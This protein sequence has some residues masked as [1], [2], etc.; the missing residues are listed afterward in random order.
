EPIGPGTAIQ[1][2]ALRRQ[3]H[4]HAGRLDPDED[5]TAREEDLVEAGRRDQALATL[6]EALEDLAGCRG[7][8]LGPATDSGSPRVRFG[9]QD[10]GQEIHDL[11]EAHS[12]RRSPDAELLLLE[13]GKLDRLV[14]PVPE[15]AVLLEKSLVLAKQPLS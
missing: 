2:V 6:I 10:Q 15:L 7:G 8:G 14:E 1:P 5:R 9:A 4:R 11:V 12:H 13:P 3:E